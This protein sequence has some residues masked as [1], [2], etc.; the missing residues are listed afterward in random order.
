MNDFIEFNLLASDCLRIFTEAIALPRPVPIV[1]ETT[2]KVTY[3]GID[4]EGSKLALIAA[5]K[6]GEM[7]KG[8]KITCFVE[9]NFP[10]M[11]ERGSIQYNNENGPCIRLLEIRHLGHLVYRLD[12]CFVEAL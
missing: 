1:K 10:K 9:Q 6:L 7:L 12:T 2:E 4:M 5:Q 8:K 3:R 11:M